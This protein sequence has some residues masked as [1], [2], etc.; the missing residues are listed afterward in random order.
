VIIELKKK[1]KKHISDL[2]SAQDIFDLFSIL[3]YPKN[4][5]LDTSYLRDKDEF[6]FKQE[7]NERINQ[8][9]SVLNFEDKLSVFLI[10]TKT[11][12][13]SFI[14]SI[15]IK[16]DVQYPRFLLIFALSNN[17][18]DVLFCVT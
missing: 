4:F 12:T 5:L 16:F 13:P 1:I 15:S 3:N 10:E 7:D 8:I 6:G 17:Y 14:R 2:N 18:S 11:L 9:Y